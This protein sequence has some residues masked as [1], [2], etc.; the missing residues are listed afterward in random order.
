MSSSSLSFKRRVSIF[1]IA[2]FTAAAA[3][4]KRKPCGRAGDHIFVEHDII[5]SLIFITSCGII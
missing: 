5:F 4:E 1:L 2:L 3:A